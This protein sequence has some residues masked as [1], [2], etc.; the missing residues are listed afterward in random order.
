MKG[1]PQPN[2][3]DG[4]SVE[5]VL[6]RRDEQRLRLEITE[7][8]KHPAKKRKNERQIVAEH[9]VDVSERD[10]AGQHDRPRRT[11]ELR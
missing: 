2:R 4:P 10:C 6:E 7:R 11:E 9:S 1:T 8:E 5:R 3:E